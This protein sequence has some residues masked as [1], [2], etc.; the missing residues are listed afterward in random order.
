MA[1]TSNRL[2][3]I[4]YLTTAVGLNRGGPPSAHSRRVSLD[5]IALEATNPRTTQQGIF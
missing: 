4:R 1:V 2:V 3:S 5:P